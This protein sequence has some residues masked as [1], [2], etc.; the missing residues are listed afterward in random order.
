MGF[1]VLPC[2]LVCI[3]VQV[4]VA[5]RVLRGPTVCCGLRGSTGPGGLE[6]YT[7]VCGLERY[8]VLRGLERYTAA[9]GGRPLQVHGGTA[10]R[11]ELLNKKY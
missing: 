1:R 3:R 9:G 11:G 4:S 5:R 7:V 6:R 2:A 8:M 10:G